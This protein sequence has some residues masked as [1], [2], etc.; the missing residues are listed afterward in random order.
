MTQLITSMLAAA[1]CWTVA[2]AESQPFNLDPVSADEF[3][4]VTG[5]AFAPD[6]SIFAAGGKDQPVLVFDK[7]GRLIHK[8]GREHI[9]AKH[10]LRIHDNHVWVTDIENHQV[11][12]FTMEGKLVQALGEKGVPGNDQTHFNKPTDL[13]FA[14]NGNIYISDGYGNSRV[15]CLSPQGTFIRAWGSP[16]KGEGQFK[17]PHNIVVNS[18]GNVYVADRGNNRIQVFSPKGDF[19]AQWR[20]FGKPYGLDIARDGTIWATVADGNKW[21]GLIAFAADGRI[22]RKVGA[23]PGRDLGCYDV[24]HSVDLQDD[25]RLLLVG[26]VKSQRIQVVTLK[27]AAAPAK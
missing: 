10:G 25:G 4:N 18:A 11:L 9:K 20:G 17:Y 21:H 1:F 23:A 13:A 3:V 26:E 12:K 19:M 7:T 16:G 5:V 22:I 2:A 27:H 6:G 24:P 15:V 8:W 14:P